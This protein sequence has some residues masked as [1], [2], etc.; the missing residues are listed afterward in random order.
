MVGGIPT[1]FFILAFYGVHLILWLIGFLVGGIPT[2]LKNMKVS[3]DDF[4]Q[5]IMENRKMFQTTNQISYGYFGLPYPGQKKNMF[6]SQNPEKRQVLAPKT[7]FWR[8]T[9]FANPSKTHKYPV[10]TRK[11]PVNTRQQ[12]SVKSR[13]RCSQRKTGFF[14]L[15][16]GMFCK[17]H[18][19]LGTW[20]LKVS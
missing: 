5:Y 10:E 7:C 18:L 8:K 9:W 15:E 2:P 6:L 11:Y 17:T 20:K 1:L 12:P 16:S 4:S 14:T 19:F 13:R 3:W